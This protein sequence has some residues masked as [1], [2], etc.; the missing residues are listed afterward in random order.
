MVGPGSK[1]FLGLT[2]VGNHIWFLEVQPVQPYLF[3]FNLTRFGA[4]FALCWPYGDIFLALRGYFWVGVWFFKNSFG[5]YLCR[6][7]T[8]V[9]EIQLYLFVFD[10]AK[11][12]AFLCYLGVLGRFEAFLGLGS[13]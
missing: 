6:Q 8:L 4:S 5:T 7:S 11:F 1:L 3:V 9:L 13:G 2:Y 12:W 10:L